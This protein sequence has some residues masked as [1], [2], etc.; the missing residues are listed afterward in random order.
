MN[1]LSGQNQQGEGARRRALTVEELNQGQ[2]ADESQAGPQGGARHGGLAESV[3][4]AMA[5]PQPAP[6]A[7][8]APQAPQPP[9]APPAKQP[10]YDPHHAGPA[11]RPAPQAPQGRVLHRSGQPARPAGEPSYEPSYEPARE[12]ARDAAPAPAYAPQQEPRQEMSGR[13]MPQLQPEPTVPPE[14]AGHV[15]AGTPPVVGAPASAAPAEAAP[16]HGTAHAPAPAPAQTAPTAQPTPAAQAAPAAPAAQ[17]APAVQP[18]P[19]LPADFGLEKEH[20]LLAIPFS[21]VIDGHSYAGEA[22]SVTQMVLRAEDGAR[23]GTGGR[24]LA[25]VLMRYSGFGLTLEPEVTVLQEAPDGQVVVQFT[26]PTGDHLP[27]L[28]YVINSYIAGDVVSMNGMLAYTGPTAPKQ[29]KPAPTPAQGRRERIRSISVL[30]L[31]A[32]IALAAAVIVFNRY[33]TGQEMH[34]VFIDRAGQQMKATVGGQIG[35]VN[36]AAGQGEVVFS[37][38][39]NTGDVLNFQMPCDCEIDMQPGVTAGTT[40]LPADLIATVY[41]PEAGPTMNTMM[42]VKGLSRTMNGDALWLDFAGG[43]SVQVEAVPTA[44]TRA[45]TLAGDM[46]LPVTLRAT[47]PSALSDADIGQTARLRITP[48]LLHRIGIN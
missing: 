9:Q 7:P 31:S 24:H 45:A 29:A 46:F 33:T 41:Q 5:Q 26:D 21:V 18:A 32:V 19:A 28:R 12:P 6:H 16:A 8:Q 4:R 1:A 2:W 38:N 10:V 14:P 37:V 36:P 48:N 39:A 11:P 17:A 23:L 22:I 25:S 44:A 30:G 40:V 13:A 42:S 43:R 15:F 27:Q 35:F 47:D 3:A 34:P 20:P